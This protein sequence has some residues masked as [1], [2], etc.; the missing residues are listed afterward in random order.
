MVIRVM[1][2]VLIVATLLQLPYSLCQSTSSG[3]RGLVHVPSA[4]YPAD[5]RIWIS[6]DSDLTWYYNYLSTPSPAY[7]DNDKLQFVPMLWGSPT[8]PSDTRFLDEV[9]SQIS[10]GA[11]IPYVLGFNEPDGAG[12]GGSNIPTDTAAQTWI[13]QIEP[14]KEQG[15]KLGAPAVTGAPGGFI[16]LEN[17]FRACNGN[18]NPDFI[19]VHWYGNFEGLASHIGQVRGTYPNMTIWVTEYAAPSASLAESIAFYNQSAQ[20]FD[21]IE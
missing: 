16:W 14:L 9:R 2:S 10:G 6:P 20:Y 21:R 1:D 8:D 13:R 17:F 18:C 12:N 4:K 7:R 19:P 11:Q 3:K 15:V 5:D